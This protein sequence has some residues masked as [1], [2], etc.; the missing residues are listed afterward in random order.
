MWCACAACV[1]SLPAAAQQPRHDGER[2]R[3]ERRVSATPEQ[4]A[5]EKTDFLKDR[6]NL[7]EKQ[8][9]KVYKLYLQQA[10]KASSV[11]EGS[12]GGPGPEG[13]E[14]GFGGGPRR[15]GMQGPPSGGGHGPGQGPRGGMRPGGSREGDAAPEMRA[16]S[17]PAFETDEEIAA[18]NKKMKKIL[19]SGQYEQ[20]SAWDR[21]E[22]MRRLREPWNGEGMPEGER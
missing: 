2:P 16:Q 17:Q 9:K 22:R 4:L 19:T 18:R 1:I 11:R 8:V 7:T 3:E 14:G 10:K 21:E 13:M 15:G 5:Q 6:L 12:H 20:W